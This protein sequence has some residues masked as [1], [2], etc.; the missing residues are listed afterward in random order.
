[1]KLA[2][3]R[4]RLGYHRL[5]F[6]LARRTFSGSDRISLYDELAFLL[7]N[8]FKI[9]DAIETLIISAGSTHSP[10][11]YCLQ[12][13]KV[14]LNNGMSLDKGL[15]GWVP[16]Q[17]L[18]LLSAGVSDGHLAAALRRAMTI[19]RATREMRSACGSALAYP[20]LLLISC[21][22]M[23]Q[24]VSQ[25]F[26]P[27]LAALVSEDQWQGA[28]KLLA[29]ISRGISGHLLILISAA[30]LLA[31]WI[32]W[33]L[34]NLTG[35]V[36]REL[37]DRLLPWKLYRDV[38]GV[39]FLLNISALLRAQ[40]KTEQSLSQLMQRASP[41]LYE[42]LDAT[43]QHVWQGQHLGAALFA[44]GY[45]FPSAE[46]VRKLKVLTAADNAENIIENFASD[47]LEKT[48]A[49][50]KRLATVTGYVCLSLNAGYMVLILLSTQ[51]LNTLIS[52]HQ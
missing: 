26:L 29:L 37:L 21:L 27:R 42:R 30:L 4:L 23:I 34:P 47:W 52:V 24:L 1:M 8:E 12:Q 44:S 10:A 6:A 7:E 46:S 17:E 31:G 36:R 28:L 49:Q 40:V 18:L 25:R 22:F 35:R 3:T 38:Q 51:D 33:S 48:V 14:A 16:E 43:L 2:S 5:G 15:Q 50:I 41:W 19:A 11:I 9:A 45:A 32:I 13:I 20:G 39:S